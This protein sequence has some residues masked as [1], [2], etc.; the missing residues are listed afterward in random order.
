MVEHPKDPHI[1]YAHLGPVAQITK[2]LTPNVYAEDQHSRIPTYRGSTHGFVCTSEGIVMIDCPMM[3]TDAIRWRFEIQKLNRGEIKY[4]INTDSHHDHCTGNG[5][6][7]GIIISTQG[8][9]DAFPAVPMK[10]T[11]AQI[12]EIDPRDNFTLAFY[13]PRK[14]TITFTDKL[15]LYCGD[16]TFQCYH[17]PG[18]TPQQCTVYCPEEKVIFPDD[19]CTPDTQP[20]LAPGNPIDWIN[21]LK[22][23]ETLDVEWVIGGHGPVG[24]KQALTDFRLFLEKCVAETK[25]AIAKGWSKEE[26]A[27]R[28]NWEPYTG[29][30]VHPG[31]GTQRR[32]VEK[33]YDVLSQQK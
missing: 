31:K 26:T 11:F 23:M 33:F 4:I 32:N 10:G 7:P 19:N 22:F 28:L 16:H 9:R 12:D 1:P 15:T 5:M 29:P 13:L 24:K 3:P 20:V 30:A 6:F 2:Q 17:L 25:E 18:H 21:S 8:V 14:P 27:E